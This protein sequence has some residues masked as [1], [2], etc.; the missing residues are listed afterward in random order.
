MT[1]L[2]FLAW[3]KEPLNIV[4][5]ATAAII[6]GLIQ[7]RRDQKQSN[8][9]LKAEKLERAY[10]LCQEIYDRHKQQVDI[11]RLYL[12]SDR[13]SY[14]DARK[15]PGAE[16]SELKML[17]RCYSPS[18][19]HLLESIDAGHK[20]LKVRFAELDEMSF[21]GATMDTQVVGKILNDLDLYL[22]AVSKGSGDIKSGIEKELLSISE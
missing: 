12:P 15:H 6:G 9:R 19:A 8:A 17:V 3:A 10:S 21:P 7:S 14:R 1:T 22:R 13:A 5:G 16:M 11:A 2:E 20:P 4:L 18:L